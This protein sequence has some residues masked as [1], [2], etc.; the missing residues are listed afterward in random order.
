MGFLDELFNGPAKVLCAV[1]G[2]DFT[3]VGIV[4]VCTSCGHAVKVAGRP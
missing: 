1:S 2:H 3:K 4:M